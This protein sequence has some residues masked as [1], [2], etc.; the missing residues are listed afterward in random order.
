M[1]ENSPRSP[2]ESIHVLEFTQPLAAMAGKWGVSIQL[3]LDEIP[4]EDVGLDADG[5]LWACTW[6]ARRKWT[7]RVTADRAAYEAKQAAYRAYCDVQGRLRQE[8]I[9]TARARASEDFMKRQRPQLA[10]SGPAGESSGNR[11][12][13]SPSEQSARREAMRQAGESAAAEWDRKH[14]PFAREQW[15]KTYR[16]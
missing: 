13:L 14:R 12:G 5:E 16:P 10:Y 3:L 2:A 6:H 8:H 7:A 11:M 4:A 15:E 9:D 1:T